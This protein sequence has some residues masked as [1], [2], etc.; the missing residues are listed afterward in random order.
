MTEI[1]EWIISP[2]GQG[3]IWGVVGIL[4]KT[5]APAWVPFLGGSQK[6][7]AELISLLKTT[8]EQNSDIVKRAAFSEMKTAEKTLKKQFGPLERV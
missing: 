8:P 1:A 7:V 6:L 3:V 4:A 2:I 5:V